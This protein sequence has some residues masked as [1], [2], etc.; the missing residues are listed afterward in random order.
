MHT[1]IMHDPL[2][3]CREE[4]MKATH[5]VGFLALV[6]C[7]LLVVVVCFAGGPGKMQQPHYRDGNHNPDYAEQAGKGDL[8]TYVQH[9]I[10]S[11]PV[12]VFSKSYCPYC[13]RAKETF[14]SLGVKIHVVEL[15]QADRGAEIQATLATLTGQRTVPNVF[16]GGKHIGGSD[17][18]SGLASENKLKPLVDAVLA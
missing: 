10:D 8:K 16:I 1:H 11:N 4:P 9:L 6:L 5:G 14:R 17:T 7:V 18:V 3:F 12:M 13:R 2:S 15:D